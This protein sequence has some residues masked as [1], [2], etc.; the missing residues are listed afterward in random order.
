MYKT[1]SGEALQ[2]VVNMLDTALLFCS[3]GSVDVDKPAARRGLWGWEATLCPRTGAIR[4]LMTDKIPHGPT[5][6]RPQMLCNCPHPANNQG[7]G[8]GA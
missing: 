1:C 2:H 4:A 5:C 6:Y 3:A 8:R 7:T